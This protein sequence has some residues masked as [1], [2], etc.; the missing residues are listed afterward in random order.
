MKKINYFRFNTLATAIVSSGVILASVLTSQAEVRTTRFDSPIIFAL[1]ESIGPTLSFC[2]SPDFNHDGL[3]DYLFFR[4]GTPTYCYFNSPSSIVVQKPYTLPP[5]LADDYAWV[6]ALPLGSTIGEELSYPEV[7]MSAYSWSEGDEYTGAFPYDYI[8][9]NRSTVLTADGVLPSSSAIPGSENISGEENS[10]VE[11]AYSPFVKGNVL[12][13]EG[14]IGIK[15][16]TK[17]PASY[18]AIP[19]PEYYTYYGYI[20]FWCP[21]EGAICFLGYSFESE[22]N[23]PI[24]AKP[25]AIP[26]IMK[27]Q[28]SIQKL[29]DGGLELS[30][31]ATPGATYQAERS[32][33]PEGPFEKVGE[34]IVPVPIS[35][36][37]P[38]QDKVIISKEEAQS[39]QTSFWRKVRLK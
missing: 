37:K 35:G 16:A 12:G 24:V 38:V 28:F 33:H 29:E 10:E 1:G 25:L 9:F 18:Y 32:F 31:L 34:E 7:D 17:I 6:A 26:P 14:V 8:S 11:A 36:A 2:F 15:F 23:Q 13:K 20:H 27:I 30:W 39:S 3:G 21:N 5:Y 19:L 22:W 4:R